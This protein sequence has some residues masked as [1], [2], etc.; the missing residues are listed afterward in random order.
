MGMW[1]RRGICRRKIW[2]R[3]LQWIVGSLGSESALPP[4]AAFSRAKRV[5]SSTKLFCWV[6]IRN[7]NKKKYE[8][9]FTVDKPYIYLI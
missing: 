9:K 6:F 7:R 5:L 1:A 3:H 2:G 8:G 4:G